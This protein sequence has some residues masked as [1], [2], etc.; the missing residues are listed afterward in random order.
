LNPLATYLLWFAGLPPGIGEQ[1]AM[2]VIASAPHGVF[3]YRAG[4]PPADVFRSH[5]QREAAELRF[6]AALYRMTVT[7]LALTL[8]ALTEA[9]FRG[10]SSAE[11]W[12]RRNESLEQDR[13]EIEAAFGPAAVGL[14]RGS[15]D[16]SAWTG[17]YTKWSEL[18]R[19]RFSDDVIMSWGS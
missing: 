5:I 17:E 1:I 14:I 12:Q 7:G 6:S 4:D 3:D 16:V 8:G 9:A 18:R 13:A 11:T 10:R 2:F 19:T 15:L